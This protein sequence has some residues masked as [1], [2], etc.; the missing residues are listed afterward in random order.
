L[1]IALALLV[2]PGC[3]G[4]GSVGGTEGEDALGSGGPSANPNGE[5]EPEGTS[6]DAVFGAAAEEFDVPAPLLKAIAWAE[7][8]W[9]MVVGE[10]EFEGQEAAYGIMALRGAELEEGAL[11][12]GVSIE[13]ARFDREAN[14]RA[15]AALLSTLADEIGI[16]RAD[17]GDW[18]RVAAEYSGIGQTMG[19][20]YYV[21]NEVYRALRE[22]ISSELATMEPT[23]VLPKFVAFDGSG[24][25]G[26]DYSP[27]IW[28]P[29]PNH[30]SRPS[31]SAGQRQM[32]IIHTCEGSYS[33]CWSWLT[34]SGSGV[35]AHYVVNSTGSEVSQL[36]REYRKGWHCSAQ[37][38]CSRNSGVKCNLNGTSCNSFTI[39]VEHAGYAS[40]SSWSSGLLNASAK[41]VCDITEDNG[42][43][44]DQFHI[45]A[46]GQVQ[47]YNRVDPGPNWPWSSYLGLVNSYC[48]STPPPE[49]P[50]DPPEDPPEDPPPGG[51]SIVVD[52]NN[53]LNGSSARCQ[54]SGAWT[55]SKNV[56]GYYNTGYWWRSTGASSDVARFEA[57]L[58][59]AKTMIVEAWWPA[60]S[61]RSPNAPFI[62]YDANGDHLDT[63][64]VNQRTNG[65]T[66]VEL[67]RYDFT[68]G[69]IAAGLSRWTGAGYVVVADAVRFREVP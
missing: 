40:Q 49:D 6:L 2:V 44:R 61:D 12:A 26:P 63:V 43:A 1:C 45:V 50:P 64:Y 58:P 14:V 23:E 33:G 65:G 48:G 69:W 24:S 66:W 5:S 29:S 53:G 57:Y 16:E 42:I 22:G 51:L 20:A 52:S 19:Q 36:V 60:A 56:P 8:E 25:P 32:V 3:M 21:H 39:G 27:A 7:T 54:V 38:K 35:S 34:N 13:Q 17:L 10:S 55:A 46:H 28:R 41:L 4:V 15:A 30:S 62:I 9:Q 18:A 47:P 11:R 37:Y 67:G 31:G 59:S 68:A